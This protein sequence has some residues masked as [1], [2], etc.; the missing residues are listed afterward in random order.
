[1][2]RVK[3]PRLLN[4]ASWEPPALL[5]ALAVSVGA[6]LIIWW[7]QAS[8]GGGDSLPLPEGVTGMVGGCEPFSVHAQNRWDPVGAKARVA[9]LREA[10]DAE[11]FAPNEL[12]AVDGWVRTRAAYPTNTTPWNS[13]VWFHLADNTGW[14]SFAAVR[15]DPTSY[16]PTGFEEDGGRP[17]PLDGDCSATVRS[18]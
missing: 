4:H 5:A 7:A 8:F 9:P 11:S 14:V 15:A 12:I 18:Q 17:V 1:M 6:G 16:D 10:A 13:D 3:K 2:R